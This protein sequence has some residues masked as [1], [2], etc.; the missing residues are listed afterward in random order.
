M[1]IVLG[2]D[3]EAPIVDRELCKSFTL[4]LLVLTLVELKSFHR[5]QTNVREGNAFTPVYQ[6]FCSEGSLSQHAIVK[7]CTPLGRHLPGQTPPPPRQ[8]PPGKQPS[9]P[10]ATEAGGTH[11]TGMLSCLHLISNSQY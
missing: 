9:S 6:S 4:L 7:G 2:D 3:K 5:P 11:P 10:M 1:V 8:T